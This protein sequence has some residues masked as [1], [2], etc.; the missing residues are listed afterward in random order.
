M[1]PE[2]ILLVSQESLSALEGIH[3]P[4][5]A[6]YD[7]NARA[8]PWRENPNPYR[9]WISEIMLQQTRVEAVRSY[10]TRFVAELPNPAALA[11]V[12]DDRLLKLWEGLGYY[13]RARNLK[14]AA[15]QIMERFAGALP[16]SY[17]ALLSLPGIGEYTA[18]AVASIAFGIP[19]PAVDGNVL[20]VLSR[21]AGSYADISLPA[22]KQ[23][24][25]Q[26]LVIPH[27][28]PGDFNQ[29]LMEL[30]ALICLP[31]AA[32]LCG[33]CPLRGVCAGYQGGCALELPQKARRKARRIEERTIVLITSQSGVLLFRRGKGLLSGMY[34]PLNLPPHLAGDALRSALLDMGASP[35]AFDYLGT[36]K[37]LFTHVEWRMQG[38]HVRSESFPAP[39]NAVWATPREVKKSYAI[40]SAFD[41]YITYLHGDSR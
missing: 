18:G 6:W 1:H 30:G 3:T 21:L 7:Q 24:Y 26:T 28:R 9:V 2:D 22:V 8:L 25:R 27:N 17:A 39:E 14:G 19:V 11:A 20:R 38:Y 37:H 33:R 23:A 35:G 41:A 34:E 15:K 32:P 12:P 5:L 13:S 4:L 36:A 31:N 40:P 10:F 29:S 16:A